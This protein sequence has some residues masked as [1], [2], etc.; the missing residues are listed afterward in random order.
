MRERHTCPNLIQ[1]QRLLLGEL[2]DSESAEISGHVE[3]CE[4]CHST[5][6]QPQSQTVAGNDPLVRLVR[7]VGQIPA[8]PDGPALER[9]IA[10]IQDRFAK[11]FDA[12]NQPSLEQENLTSILR[13]VDPPVA[14]DELGHLGEFRLLKLLGTGGMGVVFLAEDTRLQRHAALKVLRNSGKLTNE[15]RERFL[16]ESR[17][18]A[19]IKHE[20]IVTIYQS[21]EQRGVLYLVHELLKGETLQTRL[22]RENVL[23]IPESITIGQQIARG[24]A[25]AHSQGLIHRDIKPANVF[26]APVQNSGVVNSNLRRA[27]GDLDSSN[28]MNASFADLD[29]T[30]REGEIVKLLDF[31]IALSTQSEMQLT[32]SGIIIGTPSYLA[33]EQAGGEDIDARADLFSLGVVLYQMTTGKL[34][35]PGRS[36]MEILNALATLTPV[37][38]KTLNS[39]IPEVL[40]DL[41]QRLLARDPAKRPES[42]IMVFRQLAQIEAH[43]GRPATSD[44]GSHLSNGA[45]KKFGLAFAGFAASILLALIVIQI[46]TKDGTEIPPKPIA[47]SALDPAMIPETEWFDGQPKELVAVVGTHRLRDWAAISHVAFHPGGEFF[48]TGNATSQTRIWST[49]TL[50]RISGSGDPGFDSGLDNLPLGFAPDGKSFYSMHGKYSVDLTNPER[51]KLSLLGKFATHRISSHAQA[52]ISPDCRWLVMSSPYN[53]ILEFWDISGDIPRFV[54]EFYSAADIY[55]TIVGM[56]VDGHRLAHVAV[57]REDQQNAMI[58]VWE[59][60]WKSPDGP[61]L[62]P[63]CEPIP[64]RVGL[65]APDAMTLIR[66]EPDATRSQVLDLSD[67]PLR[68]VLDSEASRHFQFSPDSNWLASNSSLEI[69]LRQRTISG[70]EERSRIP[71]TDGPGCNFWFSPDGKTLIVAEYVVGLMRVWDLTANPPVER[72]PTRHYRSIEFSSDGRLLA[73]QGG[74]ASAVWNLEGGM[75]ELFAELETESYDHVPPSFSPDSRLLA[76]TGHHTNVLDLSLPIAQPIHNARSNDGNFVKF[77]PQG[78]SVQSWEGGQ[79]FSRPWEITNRGQFRIGTQMTKIA[80]LPKPIGHDKSLRSLRSSDGMY[81]NLQSEGKLQVWNLQD[82]TRPLFEVQHPDRAEIQE[83]SLSDDGG[84]LAAFTHYGKSL[85]WDLTEKPPRE[86]VLPSQT[87]GNTGPFFTSDGKLL[88]VA[89]QGGIDIHDWAAGRLVRTIK[90]PGAVAGLARHPDGQHLATVNGNGTVYILRVPELAEAVPG[91]LQ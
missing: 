20:N 48:L 5:L 17:A 82:A 90:Y 60:D 37:S 89:H 91:H 51:P 9:I 18:A 43:F 58:L 55:T 71:T 78:Q 53:D 61:T 68:V 26:L 83:F 45:K 14:P 62:T 11:D 1:L 64:G 46:R 84:L 49:K 38:P 81:V 59:V 76:F 69:A 70:W 40:S 39:E 54:R 79:L 8:T 67:S 50:E 85:V 52:V 74:E 87:H 28:V 36:T 86:Y 10:V 12:A 35:F 77:A 7:D 31:G 27:P 16:R 30:D 63:T 41:I 19:K 34:P 23:S 22:K 13:E 4:L 42:A 33:P 24:L 56:S 29:F 6:C 25:A 2:S 32:A 44:S 75:P 73:T 57:N 3:H 66:T 65:L 88:F 47:L 72:M 21:G 15:S 80:K